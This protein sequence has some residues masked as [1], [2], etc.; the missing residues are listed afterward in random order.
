MV[1]YLFSNLYIGSKLINAFTSKCS[2]S[3][4]KH[5][6]LASPLICTIFS[7]FSQTLALVLLPLSLS[8]APTVSSR[9]KITDISVTHYAP[10]YITLHYI[11]LHYTMHLFYGML[12]QKHFDNLPLI[13]LALVNLA[14]LYSTICLSGCSSVG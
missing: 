11:T 4:T 12:F 7:K 2:Q 9:L 10:V 1:F 14:P 5:C 3:R 13:H 8:N 6:N